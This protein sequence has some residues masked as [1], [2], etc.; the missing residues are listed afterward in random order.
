MDILFCLEIQWNLSNPACTGREML[1]WNK[2]SVRLHR[3]KHI[4]KRSKGHEHPVKQITQV[5]D[6]KGFTV[7]RILVKVYFNFCVKCQFVCINVNYKFIS[8]RFVFS[9]LSK[10]IFNDLCF[11]HPD[12]GSAH[13]IKILG[14]QRL[15][16]S[17]SSICTDL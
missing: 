6:K 11:Y 15:C 12:L 7:Y 3:V 13:D 1:C 5:S 17:L 9:L 4:Q 14:H 16:P 10:S 8:A 2:Q